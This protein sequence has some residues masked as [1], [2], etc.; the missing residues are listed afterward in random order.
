[1]HAIESCCVYILNLERASVAPHYSISVKSLLTNPQGIKPTSVFFFF[2]LLNAE[3]CIML[4][5]IKSSG[6]LG[7][8]LSRPVQF[9]IVK[10]RKCE[11]VASSHVVL[12]NE[13][14]IFWCCA[15]CK[16]EMLPPYLI[17]C[18]F[19]VCFS[20]YIAVLIKTRSCWTYE[21]SAGGDQT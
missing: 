3:V 4:Q 14:G 17:I 12:S 18:S 6:I 1:M 13:W 20:L 7:C 19:L 21:H 10:S 16:Q 9:K 2:L 15:E 8:T 11:G 5:T